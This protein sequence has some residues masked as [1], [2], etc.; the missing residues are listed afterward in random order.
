M[1]THC[2]RPWG[3]TRVDFSLCSIATKQV[4]QQEGNQFGN[5]TAETIFNELHQTVQ[6]EYFEQRY[7]QYC[8]YLVNQE[9]ATGNK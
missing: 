6:A 4:E 1:Q 8:V 3:F 5:H 9:V 2:K 7:S